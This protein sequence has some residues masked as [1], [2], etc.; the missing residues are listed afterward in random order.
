MGEQVMEKQDI[1]LVESNLPSALEEQ[2]IVSDDQLLHNSDTSSLYEH[3]KQ[4]TELLRTYVDN[5][6]KNSEE[7]RTGKK[8]LFCIAKV[9]LIVVPI[10]TVLV[11]GVSLY[12]TFSG[13]VEAFALFPDVILAL[14]SLL[15]TYILI[16]KMITGYLFN[17]KEEKYLSEIIGKIQD[18]DKDIRGR[19]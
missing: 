6:K 2:A 12:G 15:G 10:I 8:Q 9:L 3:N 7:K 14:G 4:Y 16:P 11:V 1:N 5:F 17:E 19:M 13:Q 18:Y